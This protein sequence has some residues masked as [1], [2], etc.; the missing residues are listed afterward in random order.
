MFKIGNLEIENNVCLAPM[1]GV[2]NSA[3]RR[4]VKEY[5]AGLLFAEMVSDKALLYDRR[6]K[7]NCSANIW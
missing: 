5:G 6:R 1:A 2:C 4:I 7:A 3:F